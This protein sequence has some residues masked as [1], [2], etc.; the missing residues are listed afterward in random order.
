[1]KLTFKQFL[2]SSETSGRSLSAD[3]A[4]DIFMD[5]VRGM[6]PNVMRSLLA[7]ILKQAEVDVD[8]SEID[9]PK[10][11]IGMI[12]NAVE[13][14]AYEDFMHDIVPPVI[15]SDEYYNMPPG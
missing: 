12:G 9:D 11:L 3:E 14:F 8:V 2:E 6:K 4:L 10:V 7:E 1:M 13:K 5:R 15:G